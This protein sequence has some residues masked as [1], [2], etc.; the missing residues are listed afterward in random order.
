MKKGL[1]EG[2]TI[3][4]DEQRTLSS[5]SFSQGIAEGFV[6]DK[7]FGFVVKAL[8]PIDRIFAIIDITMESESVFISYEEAEEFEVVLIIGGDEDE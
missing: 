5:W 1:Q 6:R 8:M 3:R 7:N 2:E 4:I